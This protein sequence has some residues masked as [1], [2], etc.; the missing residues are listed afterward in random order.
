MRPESLAAHYLI[1]P[2]RIKTNHM[3]NM[4]LLTALLSLSLFAAAQDEAEKFIFYRT[5]QWRKS[6]P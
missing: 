1:N 5:H 4:M 2:E 6:K 3:K